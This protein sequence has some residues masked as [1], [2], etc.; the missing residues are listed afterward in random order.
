MQTVVDIVED[1]DQYF[2]MN[3]PN[4]IESKTY[5]FAL[6]TIRLCRYLI[7]EKKEYILSK[8]LVRSG[9]SVGANVREAIHAPTK[10]DFIYKMSIALKEIHESQYWIQL[11]MDSE[12]AADKQQKFQVL[13]SNAIEIIALLTS[14]I[15][16]SRVSLSN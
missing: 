14:I 9:T 4:I 11:I 15:K 8:Q 13:Q 3:K 2:R 10:K 1:R 6:N 12:F 5:D 16:S 7:D